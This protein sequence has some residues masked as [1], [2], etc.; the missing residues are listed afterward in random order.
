VKEE[1][2]AYALILLPAAL[3]AGAVVGAPLSLSI[4][5]GESMYPT[6]RHLDMVVLVSVELMT[7]K[8]GD[9]GVY[10]SATGLVMHR[11]ASVVGD[12]YIFKGDNN[13]T[14]DPP[15]PAEAVA[16]K[17]VAVLPGYLWAPTLSVLLTAAT[18][19]LAPH[20]TLLPALLVV[21]LVLHTASL[22]DASPVYQVKPVPLPGE[23]KYCVGGVGCSE[24][25]PP[26]DYPFV[27]I[28]R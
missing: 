25:E 19:L 7:I 8:P 18:L 12:T 1:A 17:V 3:M 5:A 13:P 15:V 28:V 16:Y 26:R 20:R 10:R 2:A 14:P 9:I 21:A 6:V 27:V 23:E 4:A 24:L 22:S 11:V